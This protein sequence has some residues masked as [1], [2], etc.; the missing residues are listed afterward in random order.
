MELFLFHTSLLL[1]KLKCGNPL[2]LLPRRP[3]LF[4][5]HRQIGICIQIQRHI[6]SR[7]RANGASKDSLFEFK[8]RSFGR[9]V[10]LFIYYPPLENFSIPLILFFF[11][12]SFCSSTCHSLFPHEIRTTLFENLLIIVAK[13]LETGD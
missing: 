13:T 5:Y 7:G 2:Q 10:Y 8:D 11:I 9:D 1:L 6:W 3:L 4:E 12:G